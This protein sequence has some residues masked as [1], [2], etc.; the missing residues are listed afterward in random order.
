M[1]SLPKSFLLISILL[2]TTVFANAQ[3][4]QKQTPQTQSSNG[5]RNEQTAHLEPTA[6]P[7]A[8]Q[9]ERDETAKGREQID[10]RVTEPVSVNIARDKLF[11]G[12]TIGF[13]AV[14][15]LFSCLLWRVSSRQADISKSSQRAY[16]YA[17]LERAE[18][19]SV[20]QRPGFMFVLKNFGNSPA[21]RVRYQATWGFAVYP[22]PD[23]Y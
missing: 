21:Y 14:L 20:G 19:I 5:A 23:T 15:A 4:S 17:K 7:K 11:V 10:A 3:S 13:N 6:F 8:A 9:R 22:M 16:V 2:N 18:G 12:F 1:R